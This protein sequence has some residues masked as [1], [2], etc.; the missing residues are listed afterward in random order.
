MSDVE[1]M[2]SQIRYLRGDDD[3]AA[4]VGESIADCLSGNNKHMGKH[5][6]KHKPPIAAIYSRL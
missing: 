1:A 5:M 4:A 3:V 6:G 2:E